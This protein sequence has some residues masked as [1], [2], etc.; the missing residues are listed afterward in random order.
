MT[1]MANVGVQ[2]V[3]CAL[4]CSTFC[5]CLVVRHKSNTK[6]EGEVCRAAQFESDEARTAFEGATSQLQANKTAKATGVLAIPFICWISRDEVL[7]D[8]AIYNDQL[9][10]CD[11]NHDGFVS[12]AEAQTHRTAVDQVVRE[13]TVKK[14]LAAKPAS[15]AVSLK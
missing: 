7:S 6:R 10:R 11:S 4:V 13:E 8:N 14:E 12:L 9:D 5:G 3:C 1:R 15:D 2:L